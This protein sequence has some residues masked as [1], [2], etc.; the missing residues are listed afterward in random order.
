MIK[1][2]MAAHKSSSILKK[3]IGVAASPNILYRIM[4]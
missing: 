4:K 1:V 3:S 2:F